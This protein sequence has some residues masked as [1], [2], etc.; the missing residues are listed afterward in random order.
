MKAPKTPAAFDYDLWTTEE[1]KCMV[2]I[3]VTGEVT[4]V[5]RTVMQ[6]LRAEEKRLR[7]ASSLKQE[8]CPN[9]K[10]VPATLSL[11]ALPEEVT[12]SRW[13]A[14]P[15]DFTEDLLLSTSIL[16]FQKLLT[17]NQRFV[18]QAVILQGSGVREYA[19]EKSISHKSVVETLAL[20][21]K[22]AEKFF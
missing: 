10:V 14:N 7:R 1:G 20:I 3:K 18:F 4:E 12:D 16:E 17:E 22:K 9:N 15:C 21:R 19:R 13:L 2:R 5:T 11:D 8:P 6:A